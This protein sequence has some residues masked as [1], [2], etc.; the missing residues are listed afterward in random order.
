MDQ[1]FQ[2]FVH[3]NKMSYFMRYSS[4]KTAKGVIG[5]SSDKDLNL[6]RNAEVRPCEW[7]HY[8]FLDAAGIRQEFK[9]YAA[10]AGLTTFIADECEQYYLLTNSRLKT[11]CG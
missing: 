6:W 5:E 10:N 7:P 4:K 3:R 8:P 11:F 1:K 2:N 9:Q